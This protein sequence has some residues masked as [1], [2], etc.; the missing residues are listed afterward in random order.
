MRELSIDIE[1]YSEVDL[2]TAGVYKY[3][4]KA[5]VLLFAYSYGGAPVK[6][7]DLTKEELPEQIKKDLV[8]PEVIKIAHN[9]QFER[10]VLGAWL[11]LYLPP[12]QWRCTMV[13]SL[14]AGYPLSLD[15]AS[16][17]L[18]TSEKKDAAG[19]ALIT[20]FC[21][22][23]KPTKANGG[24]TRNLPE[25]APEKWAQFI[26]Y[27]IQDVVTEQAISEKLSWCKIPEKEKLLWDMD[28]RINERGVKADLRLV[29]S[30]I[31]MDAEFRE[32]LTKEAIAITGLNN[33]NSA[34]Q[35]KKWLQDNITNFKDIVPVKYLAKAMVPSSDG[36][37][38]I[39]PVDDL[40]LP[41][42][43]IVLS[44][45][46]KDSVSDLLKVVAD[47]KAKRILQIRVEMSKTSVKKYHAILTSICSDMRVRGM[48]Q[49]CGAGRTHRWAGRIVQLHNL[50]RITYEDYDL[51]DHLRELVLIGDS[52]TLEMCFGS[53]PAQLSELIR[54][55]FIPEKGN[56]LLVGDFKAIEARVL[57]WLAGEQW[58]LDIFN[59]D[60]KIYEASASAM[61]N[62]PVESIVK[63]GGNYP[64]RQKGKVAELAC[65]YQ[66]GV[67]ALVQM[68]GADMGLTEEEMKE[69]IKAWRKASPNIVRLWY[70]L[71]N[72]AIEAIET[73]ELVKVGDKGLAFKMKHGNL[74]FRLPCGRCLVY[75][76]ASVYNYIEKVPVYVEVT[77]DGTTVKQL[78][79]YDYKKRKKIIF[80]AVNPD[81]RQWEKSDT[82][83]GKL[84]ENAVQAISRDCLA[85]GMLNVEEAGYPIV[86]HVHD[87]IVAELPYGK[88]SIKEMLKLMSIVPSW[89]KGLPLAADGA[90]CEYYSK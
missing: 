63:G 1:S 65:G 67:G 15:E 4:E 27:C 3:A 69:I 19:K 61:F 52:D 73:G 80:Y 23:C 58:R 88:G 6:C 9:A 74:L 75:P 21:V 68:G 82:Y 17:A 31:K 36:R 22:P 86:I 10:T 70:S 37:G 26:Q 16:K 89:A 8:D 45:L 7:I 42:G 44:S 50:P 5:E 55:N 32:R 48:F 38:V 60:G 71:Q 49:F 14:S 76:K 62:A 43:A 87:E 79:H 12:E 13:L 83:G 25:H 54:T 53:I 28:Q 84:C 47:K 24:R 11:G 46:T 40:P 18:G 85:E 77:V 33:P 66:G 78:D 2:K 34:A 57:A 51:L 59:G 30:A 35:L 72:A 81:T 56:R 29:R 90:E 39:G 20:Y 64:L 41:K